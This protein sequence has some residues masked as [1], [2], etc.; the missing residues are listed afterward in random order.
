MNNHRA[1]FKPDNHQKSA[2]AL[3]IANVHNVNLSDKLVNFNLGIIRKVNRDDL[4][5]HE[6]IFIEIFKARII[7]LNRSKVSGN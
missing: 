6:D 2:L 5:M 4:N 1:A 7:G 3:H